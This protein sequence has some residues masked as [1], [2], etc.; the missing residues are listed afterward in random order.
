MPSHF[1]SILLYRK[2]IIIACIEILPK[3][4]IDT[5]TGQT[6]CNYSLRV[7]CYSLLFIICF[8]LVNDFF[9]Y[10]SFFYSLL[11]K[12][13]VIINLFQKY[14][15]RNTT[16]SYHCTKKLSFPLRVSSVNVTNSAS[17]RFGNIY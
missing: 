6:F 3:I 11:I 5:L 10:Y 7:I 14:L 8:F 16:E 17:C 2:I 13:L 15:N 9:P 4:E 12:F 1:F